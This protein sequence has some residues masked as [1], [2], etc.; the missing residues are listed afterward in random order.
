MAGLP[1]ALPLLTAE[2]EASLARTIEAGV[3]AAAVLAEHLLRVDATRAELERIAA[4]GEQARERFLLSNLRLVAFVTNGTAGRDPV[5]SRQEVFQEG[6]AAMAGVLR[7]YDWRRG[8][9]STIAVPTIRRRVIEYVASRGGTLGVPAH[10]AVLIRRA[11]AITARLESETRQPAQLQ[12]VADELGLSE[13][14]TA[15]LLR[16]QAPLSIDGMAPET[17][18]QTLAVEPAHNPADDPITDLSRLP[19]TQREA[20]T[21]RYGLADGRPRSYHEIAAEIGQSA[22]TAR[23]TCEQGLAALRAQAAKPTAD[24]TL[25]S[26]WARIQATTETLRQID[27]LSK[28]GLS[29]AE[30]AIALDTEPATL[31][32]IC[33]AGHRQDLLARFGRLEQTYGFEPGPYTAPYVKVTEESARRRERFLGATTTPDQTRTRSGLG[34]PV[35]YEMVASPPEVDPRRHPARPR[36][37]A[38]RGVDTR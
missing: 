12:A 1:G 30:V 33:Q 27:R 11:R 5:L 3:A 18:E 8:R 16:H 38:G 37:D 28:A 15:S 20:L 34:P 36:P 4:E 17:Q 24:D 32:D 22:S 10:R 25:T 13:A 2:E 6:V 19:D 21:L 29:I 26:S 9:F 35:R 7:S 14:H 23:R 31:N